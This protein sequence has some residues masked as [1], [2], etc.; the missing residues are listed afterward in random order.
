MLPIC[1]FCVALQINPLRSGKPGIHCQPPRLPTSQEEHCVPKKSQTPLQPVIRS[2]W[3]SHAR[4][5][6]R[7]YDL[8]LSFIPSFF[9]ES[10]RSAACFEDHRLKWSSR[11]A[12]M[13]LD[14]K[15]LPNAGLL[16]A[17]GYRQVLTLLKQAVSAPCRYRFLPG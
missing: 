14:T 11:V 2:T 12:K 5:A 15:G 4:T 9:A 16:E 10:P 13:A 6:K 8:Y 7:N 1:K 3:S 17:H